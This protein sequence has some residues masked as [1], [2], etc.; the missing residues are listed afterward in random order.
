MS[1]NAFDNDTAHSKGADAHKASQ[2][3]DWQ[4]EVEFVF[5][6]VYIIPYSVIRCKP[7]GGFIFNRRK[8]RLHQYLG[9]L[10]PGLP[11]GHS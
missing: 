1:E 3:E 5:F 2:Y 7:F 6:H 8:S 10:A 4:R 9:R 11:I